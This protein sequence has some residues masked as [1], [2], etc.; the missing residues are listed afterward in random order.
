[1]TMTM[2]VNRTQPTPDPITST[3]FDAA[4]PN[5]G[6]VGIAD[7]LYRSLNCLRLPES[8]LDICADPAQ[9]PTYAD[10]VIVDGLQFATDLGIQCQSIGWDDLDSDFDRVL[11]QRESA[12]VEQVLANVRFTGAAGG[13]AATDITPSGGAVKPIVGLALLEG[14]A[15]LNYV[16]QPLLH[17]GRTVGSLL[18][19]QFGFKLDGKVLRTPL[20]SK[21]IAG[22]GYE[23][24]PGPSG[25]AAPAGEAWLYGSGV[26]T[27]TR[28]P[29]LRVAPMLDRTSNVVTVRSQ[30]V[31]VVDV[32]CYLSAVR[33]T[34]NG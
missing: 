16:G 19:S 18:A 27:I 14:D 2:S 33:V 9:A 7:G 23:N 17:A 20:G 6:P 3:L 32:D 21:L 5:D 15:G 8:N 25:S 26:V 29:R 11:D 28:G 31:Y 24:A 13:D 30:R 12:A 10:A 34:L 1:M 4:P 22:A